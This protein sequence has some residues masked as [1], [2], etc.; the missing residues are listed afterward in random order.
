MITDI[1]QMG[2]VARVMIDGRNGPVLSGEFVAKSS[3]YFALQRGSTYDIYDSDAHKVTT[4]GSSDWS[5]RR[6]E[7]SL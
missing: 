7:F 2:Q 4:L 3:G 6:G 5:R 1:Q